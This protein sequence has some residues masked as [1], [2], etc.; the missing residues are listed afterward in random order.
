[1]TQR[2]KTPRTVKKVKEKETNEQH[3]TDEAKTGP[4]GN[5]KDIKCGSDKYY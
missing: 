2:V 4:S 3:N 5:M 1:M